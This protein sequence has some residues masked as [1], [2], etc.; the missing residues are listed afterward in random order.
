MIQFL[1]NDELVE[2][3]AFAADTTVLSYLREH[4]HRSGTKEGCASGDCGACTVVIATAGED[5]LSYAPMNACIAPLGSLHGK[6]LI[7]VEDLK[8]DEVL[9]PVQQALVDYHGSQCGFCTPGFVMSLFA[10]YHES[11]REAPERD[12]IL[13]ALGGNLCRCTGY[14]PIVEAAEHALAGSDDD[15]FT[16]RHARTLLVLRG[17]VYSDANS[18]ALRDKNSFYL[19]PDSAEAVVQ[20][21]REHPEARLVA[22]ATD[23]MLDVTQK[24]EQLPA[25]IDLCAV[26]DLARIDVNDAHISLSAA[27]THRDSQGAVLADYP[28]LR[29][30]IERFGSLQIRA[31]GTVIGN[32]A[33]ASPIGDWP[34]VLMALD[35]SL[36]LEGPQGRRTLS[37]DDFFLAY[38]RT[39]LLPGEFIRSVELPR[40]ADDLFLRAYK[41]SKRYEDDISSVCGVFALH[42]NGAVIEQI[43]VAF[44]GLAAVPKRA[45]ACEEALRSKPL[46]DTTVSHAMTALGEDF[47]PISDARASAVYR[48]QVAANLVRRLQLELS[49]QSATRVH[50]VHY[51]EAGHG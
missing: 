40:R 28:E 44:G 25:L 12:T 23:L 17:I 34:P 22:G 6:Q 37:I 42:M 47:Q 11:A 32:I 3:E 7:T 43:R 5:R 36:T 31:Q 27:V 26:P 29:E 41:I 48:S 19:R 14:R 21:L 2:L 49:G 30:L 45:L 13:E 8:D 51:R 39:A 10:L 35:A 33:N 46:D 1:Q 4:C 16:R 24:L 15:K 20:L 9:H 38:R 18:Q 50:P